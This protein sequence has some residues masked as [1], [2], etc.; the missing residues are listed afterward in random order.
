MNVLNDRRTIAG[1]VLVL[2][3]LAALASE[4]LRL[5]DAVVLASIAIVLLVA[6]ALSQRYGFLV[7]GMILAFG[8]IGVGLQDAG[9][10]PSGGLVAIAFAS[11]FLGVYVVDVFV[12]DGSRWWP[13]IPGTILALIGTN[14]MVE[15][16]GGSDIVARLW[17]IVLVIAGLVVLFAAWRRTPTAPGPTSS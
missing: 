13:L 15:N 5:T 2:L 10:D 7:P 8:S 17:P 11:G 3:G 4:W 16:A 1:L 12:H 6:Y 14:A 9:Y